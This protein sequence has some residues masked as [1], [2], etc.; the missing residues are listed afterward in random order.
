LDSP[1]PTASGGTYASFV[2]GLT[3]ASEEANMENGM[4]STTIPLDIGGQTYVFL[5]NANVTGNF[6]TAAVVAG[7]IIEVTPNSPTL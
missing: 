1:S 7:P 2:N 5:T 4:V 3:V 6:S